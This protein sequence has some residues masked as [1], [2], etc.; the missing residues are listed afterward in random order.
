MEDTAG[1]RYLVA[2]LTGTVELQS[3][4]IRSWLSNT[5]PEHMLPAHY[6]QLK[7]LPFTTSGK[8]DKK[9]LPAPEGHSM[10]AGGIFVAPRYA[11]EEELIQVWQQVLGKEKI[12]IEDNFFEAGGNSLV[13]NRLSK[14]VKGVWGE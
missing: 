2:Y 8:I 13:I 11:I 1:D 9:R 6:I 12:G 3:S 10:E 5:L 7:E 14:I 4:K